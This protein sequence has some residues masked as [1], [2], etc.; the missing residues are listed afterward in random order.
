MTAC[1][2]LRLLLAKD[3]AFNHA[4]PE[5]VTKQHFL[6]ILRRSLRLQGSL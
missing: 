6:K 4:G 5:D 3:T 2:L 1:S